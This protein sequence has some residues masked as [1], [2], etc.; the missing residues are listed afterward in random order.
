MLLANLLAYVLQSLL[1][2][3]LPACILLACL[4]PAC[5]LYPVTQNIY[6]KDS[7]LVRDNVVRRKDPARNNFYSWLWNGLVT[8]KL[9][10]WSYARSWEGWHPFYGW[11]RSKN[12]RDWKPTSFLFPLTRRLQKWVGWIRAKS[13][14]R[15]NE[16]NKG[17]T[18]VRQFA[19]IFWNLWSQIGFRVAWPFVQIYLP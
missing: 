19:K 18:S 5:S 17:H 1:A 2:S 8:H 14:D 4:L 12:T 6:L 9:R 11:A 15:R 16:G 7:S 10:W 13:S 3:I